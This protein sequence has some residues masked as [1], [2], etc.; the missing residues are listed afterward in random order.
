MAAFPVFLHAPAQIGRCREIAVRFPV[1]NLT[2][3]DAAE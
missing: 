3:L 1:K 2:L